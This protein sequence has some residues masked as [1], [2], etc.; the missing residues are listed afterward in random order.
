MPALLSFRPRPLLRSLSLSL[1]LA[2]GAAQAEPQPLDRIIAVVNDG[3]VLQ[4]ELDR[5]ISLSTAQLRERGIQPPREDVLRTQ[6]MERLVTSRLQTQK[7]AEAGIRI[8]DRE[9]NEVLGNIAAQNG[10][11]LAAFAD[12]VRKDG[13]DFL[14][15]R[16]QVRD[17]VL[18]ARV[19]QKEVD[20]RVVVTDQ[21]IDLFLA[22]RSAVDDTE[23]RLSHILVALPEG[24]TAEQRDAARAKAN[25]LLERLN[26]GEDFAQLAAADSDGQQA[27][28]GGDL[29]WRKGSDL[30]G[31]FAA[32]L[33]RLKS[34]QVSEVLES[35]GGFHL[36]KLTGKRGGAEAQTVQ[37]TRARH[38]LLQANAI[39]DEDATLAQA[40]ELAKR[41]KDG[42]VFEALAKQYSDDPGSKNAGGDLGFT[43]A[44]VFVPE[45]Q[46]RLDQLQPGET[47]PPF[48]TQ[49]GWH[50]AQVIERRSR[51][52]T[53]ET[54][55]LKARQAI[56]ARKS[57]EEYDLWLRRIRDEAYIEFRR[58]DGKPAAAATDSQS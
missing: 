54:R 51:D 14:S 20:S 45:F 28:Q 15:V 46:I 24:A 48:H 58:A 41:L 21:D 38:I 42:E 16:E 22:N 2:T 49:F 7:A 32:A 55:R 52:T 8:D 25:G 36:I 11:S 39:R 9:L 56:V 27:L 40:Q 13:M 34:D 37:E 12:A 35:A 33:P 6:V 43:P 23:Y 10:L 26:K 17:E 4:S 29:D 19:K 18:V 47:S 44:G 5:S 3:V 57:A 30:P 31:L 50:I 53:E 1:L